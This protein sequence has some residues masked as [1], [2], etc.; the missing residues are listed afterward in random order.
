MELVDKLGDD[1]T[2]VNKARVSFGAR[3]MSFQ[4][5]IESYLNS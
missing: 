4:R 2:P 3:V 1:L 5:K